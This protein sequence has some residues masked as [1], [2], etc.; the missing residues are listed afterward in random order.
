V[1]KTEAQSRGVVL[2]VEETRRRVRLA[3][4]YRHPHGLLSSSMGNLQVLPDGHAL[5]CWGIEPY[6]SEYSADGTLLADMRL[7]H[8]H[9]SYRAFRYP[10]AGNPAESP[11]VAIRRDAATSKPTV[12]A[13]WNGATAVS[14]WL[15]QAGPRHDAMQPVGIARRRGFE[16]VI[17][18]GISG[19]YVQA[20]ALDARGRSLASSDAV[21]V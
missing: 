6:V 10:W 9:D 15:V 18:L 14:H 13:S 19:R 2:D 1:I 17:P 12:Y 11:A 21:R 8:R 4:S 3:R 20:T 16:T 5:V 7:G